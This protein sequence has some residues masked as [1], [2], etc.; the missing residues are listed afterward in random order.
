[1]NVNSR[2]FQAFQKE[3]ITQRLKITQNVSFEFFNFGIFPP[4]FVL[5]NVIRRLVTLFDRKLIIF[6]IF[7][8]F[9]STQNVNVAR[10]ARN[11][12]CDFLYDFQ[13]LCKL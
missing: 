13:T 4:I 5:S 11:F 10:F 8:D 7:N 3:F 9:L 12:E 2:F 1:M 6:G